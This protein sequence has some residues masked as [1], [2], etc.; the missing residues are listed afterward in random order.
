[1]FCTFKSKNET[2][3]G[4]LKHFR[5]VLVGNPITDLLVFLKVRFFV[6]SK[7]TYDSSS[8]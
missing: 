3:L 2:H 1:M 8:A 6:Y 7:L 4:V 5:G